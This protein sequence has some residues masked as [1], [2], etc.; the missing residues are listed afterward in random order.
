MADQLLALGDGFVGDDGGG[1]GGG[2]QGGFAEFE[3]ETPTV[4]TDL[5]ITP[6]FERA[7]GGELGAEAD[8]DEPLARGFAEADEGLKRGV[9]VEFGFGGEV[10]HVADVIFRTV[11]RAVEAEADGP[12]SDELEACVVDGH[13]GALF[14][15]AGGEADGLL[16]V[17]RQADEVSPGE[18]AADEDALA[19]GADVGVV[20]GADGDGEI[21]VAVFEDGRALGEPVFEHV[22]DALTEEFR[23]EEAAVE[24]DGVGSVGDAV[25]GEEGGQML[26]DGGVGDIGQ[27]EFAEQ[28][29][30]VVLR[31][32]SER[33]GGQEAVEG[34]LEGFRAEN[35]GAEGAA[36]ERAAGTEDRDLHLVEIGFVQQ[37]FFG[38]GALAPEG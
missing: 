23:D 37:T 14:A 33:G 11:Q 35:L 28:A 2:G 36:D 19:A 31:P 20:G 17:R 12:V 1:A 24:Q 30:L 5:R 3:L 32:F 9:G 15:A 4:V 22:G 38:S 25:V 13:L 10:D 7:D 16:A 6:D 26:G 18:A 8:G 27:A 29:A 34:E 21:E